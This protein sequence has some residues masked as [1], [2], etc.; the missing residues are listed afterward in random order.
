VSDAPASG[1]VALEEGDERTTYA[2]LEQA[3]ATAARRLATLGVGPG[4]RVA[5]TLP[6]G[7]PFA[8]LLHAVPRLGAALVPLDPR[9]TAVERRWRVED[10]AARVTVEAPLEGPEADLDLRPDPDPDALHTVLYTSGSTARPK[11]VELTWA[12]HRASAAASAANLGTAP[13][14]RWLCCLPVHH[15]GGL[16]ILLRS[17]IHGSTAVLHPG[18]EAPRVTAELAGGAITLVSLV[19]TMVRRLAEAGFEGA[20]GLRAALV[21]GGP[22]PR[23]VLQWG[24]EHGVPLVQ[25]YG[26]TET[27]SQVATLGVDEA[28]AHPGS[29]GRPLPGVEL[30][31]AGAEREILVRGS[32]VAR[33]A[34]GADGWLHTGDAGRLDDEGFLHV[35]GRLA[36]VI[37]TGG[38]NVAAEE[39]EEV[40]LAHPA[41]AEAAVVGRA[42]PEWGEAVTAYVV[43]SEPVTE[44]ELRSFCRGRLAP[45]KVPKAVH[46]VAELPRTAA[47]KV[48]RREIP[49]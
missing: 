3:S 31:V 21:G 24:A 35:E 29:A 42:D 12:N 43:V 22:V 41:V 48:V 7:I 4:D 34:V 30:A 8:V 11:R 20:P 19:A 5:T 17:A 1:R 37:V 47:G 14:D 23:G 2:E 9:L 45:F 32:M 26:M 25:T 38:E 36:N 33:G 13:E 6:A 39:V 28:L 15:V 27:A 46:E 44:D 16:A 49:R 18:F 10:A 40:L